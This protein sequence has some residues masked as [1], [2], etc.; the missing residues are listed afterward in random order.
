MNTTVKKFI[1]L[2]LGLAVMSFGSA[3]ALVADLGMEPWDVLND[4][5]AK[6]LQGHIGITLSN[7]ADLI[8]FGRANITIGLIILLIDV[9]CGEKVGFGTFIN[10]LLCGNIVD[11]CTGDL[12]PGFALL[13]DYRGLAMSVSFLPRLVLCVLSLV[14]A[15]LG[16]YIYM[17][18]RL[19]SGPRD[20]L[21]CVLT[22][23]LKSWPVGA[24]R[25]MLEGCA[26]LVGWALGG[27]VG[28][29]T[30]ILVCL[31]GPVM[32]LIFKI[33]KFDVRELRHE[34][35]PET[36]ANIRAKNS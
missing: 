5:M 23:K 4:G 26:L 19:G 35:I 22:R 13:P 36:V 25:V 7:G 32:Q 31:S 6:F 28:V 1:R 2:I 9:L 14:P 34:T 15:A 10:I 33:F 8:T 29:G 21:M 18:A 17:S 3:M 11:L 24:I 20:G 30:I 16:M 27:V 12:I